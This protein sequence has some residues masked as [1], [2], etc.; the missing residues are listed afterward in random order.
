VA[1]RLVSMMR[2]IGEGGQSAEIGL[3]KIVPAVMNNDAGAVRA[4][5]QDRLND[6][7][8]RTDQYIGAMRQNVASGGHP[9]A[10]SKLLADGSRVEGWTGNPCYHAALM[11]AQ[12]RV[13]EFLDVAFNREAAHAAILRYAD[14]GLEL[15]GGSPFDAERFRSTLESQWPSRV[16]PTIPLLLHAH[17]LKPDAKYDQ[18]AK[19][20]FEDLLKLVERNPHGYFPAWTFRPGA[21]KYDTVYNP[22]SVDRGLA[23]IWYEDAVD[24]IG[25]ENAARFVAAQA[26]WFVYSGQLLDTLEMDNVTAIR[27]CNHGAHTN[28][29]NQIGLYL[30]DDFAFYRG[31]LGDLVD[32][33]AASLEVANPVDRSGTGA[34]RALIVSDAG[35][36]LVQWGLDIHPGGKWLESKAEPLPKGVGFQVRVYNRVPEGRPSVRV[37]AKE[38]GLAGED[39]VVAEIQLLAP[40][41]REPATF[42]FT[43]EGSDLLIALDKPAKLRLHL[44]ALVPDWPP[45]AKPIVRVEG[46][47][48]TVQVQSE[49]EVVEFQLQRGAFRL[50]R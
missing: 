33:S 36:P 38:A 14:F 4:A 10:G 7:V 42:A 17:S 23:S 44:G 3:L 27:A 6:V 35:S 20:L 13:Q 5:L 15:L 37:S 30:Y 46:K 47:A 19:L 9:A 25:R 39:A 43:R 26:R 40:A 28:I 18:A 16:V 8:A 11:P 41:Y 34:Y 49:R 50:S 29:R 21:D 31:L 12:V 22:V 45:D 2:H 24:R 32:F 1:T 48:E